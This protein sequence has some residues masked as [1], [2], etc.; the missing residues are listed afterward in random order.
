MIS[1]TSCK[2]CQKMSRHLFQ[3]EVL[4]TYQVSYFKCDSCGFVQTEDPFWLEE[5]YTS[6]ISSLDVG[7]VT[8][9]LELSIET[10]RVIR[11]TFNRNGRFVDYAGGYGLLV[12]MMRDKGFDFYREERH[13]ANI[14]AQN[15]DVKDIG[16]DTG[17]DLLTAFEVFEHWVD[18]TL[19]IKK[20]FGYADSILFS[21]ALIP[22]R[23]AKAEDWWYFVPETGQHISFFS[24]KSI[25]ILAEK[26][27]CR[28]HSNRAD[29]H[30]LT[31][32]NIGDPFLPEKKSILVRATEK[33]LRW[34]ARSEVPMQSLLA[35]DF[36]VA[37]QKAR[38]SL[39]ENVITNSIAD[40]RSITL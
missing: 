20:L 18:P 5:A 16:I 34:A 35:K 21:T 26:L 36:E 4:C 33:Y 3:A 40:K 28:F 22:A 12:R 13:C 31:K 37:R 39:A 38:M 11:K 27:N 8:R 9:N 24:K 29:L 2:I 10:D 19:E 15:Y 23:V 17:F 30:L 32:R 1:T 7:L 6:A 25:E 14:F